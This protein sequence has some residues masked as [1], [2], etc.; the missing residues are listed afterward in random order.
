MFILLSIYSEFVLGQINGGFD[1]NDL[2]GCRNSTA[3]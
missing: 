2:S 3:P 1:E